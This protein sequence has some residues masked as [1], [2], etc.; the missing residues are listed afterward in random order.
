MNP[1]IY[2]FEFKWSDLLLLMKGSISNKERKVKLAEARKRAILW[3]EREL[4]KNQLKQQQNRATPAVASAQNSFKNDLEDHLPA[5]ISSDVTS[6]LS[7][8]PTKESI[9]NLKKTI[10]DLQIQRKELDI[11]I[12]VLKRHLQQ[13]SSNY[14]SES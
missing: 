3:S 13:V 2:H 5:S 4:R 10:Q 12:K 7:Q 1:R 8:P 11:T 9:D 6:V 14:S